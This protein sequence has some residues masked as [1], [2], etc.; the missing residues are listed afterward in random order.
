MGEGKREKE[1]F[2]HAR[3]GDAWWPRCGTT[4]RGRMPRRCTISGRCTSGPRRRRRRRRRA[5]DLRTPPPPPLPLPLLH[6]P[7]LSNH[8]ALSASDAAIAAAESLV[9]LLGPR[10]PPTLHVARAPPSSLLFSLAHLDD[11]KNNK[12]SFLLGTRPTQSTGVK[13][14]ACASPTSPCL[15]NMASTSRSTA[16]TTVT[17]GPTRRAFPLLCCAFFFAR[18]SFS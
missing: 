12:K 3:L 7:P 9:P 2:A 10:R 11:F 15:R 8:R 18:F 13:S 5:E 14:S 6:P 1:R 16:T 17:T 4:R